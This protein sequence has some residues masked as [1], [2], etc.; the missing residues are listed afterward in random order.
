MR[1]GG[2]RTLEPMVGK[3][4]VEIV[5]IDPGMVKADLRVCQAGVLKAAPGQKSSLWS[6]KRYLQRYLRAQTTT[7]AAAAVS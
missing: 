7:A 2:R 6:Q 4:P 1:M 5:L 3:K